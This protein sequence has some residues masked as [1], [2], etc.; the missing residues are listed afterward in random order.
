MNFY[1]RH[2]GD[3]ARDTGHLS[4]LEHGAYTLL[5]DRYY[6]TEK[7]IPAKQ[8]ERLARATTKPERDAVKAVLDEYFTLE[9]DGCW[10]HKRVDEE[11]FSYQEK[12]PEREEKKKNERDRQR[13]HRERRAELFDSLREHGVIPKYDTPTSELVTLLSRVTAEPVTRD[14][15]ATQSP[16]PSITTANAV[17]ADAPPDP[18]FGTGLRFLRRKGVPEKPARAFLGKLRKNLRDDVRVASLLARC[19][20]DDVTEPIPWLSKAVTNATN[21][22]PSKT[23]SA[24]Q[25]LE[26]L[27][28]EVAENGNR[29][30][31]AETPLL[32]SERMPV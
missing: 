3:Y 11:I 5:L 13:R 25:R 23:M 28:D 14:A 26:G 1:E 21:G 30:G 27:K 32:A 4:L 10:H 15:T 7:P 22:S 31:H 20:E 24:I 16:V 8:A 17:G 19:E 2:L 29:D 12:E 6:S 18:I 9:D